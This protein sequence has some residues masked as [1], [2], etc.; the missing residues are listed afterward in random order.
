MKK[1]YATLMIALLGSAA[2]AQNLNTVP[3]G[4]HI[5]R[6]VPQRNNNPSTQATANFYVDYDFSDEDYQVNTNGYQYSRFIWDM[7][8][9][10]DYAAGD[11]SYK[12]AAVDFNTLIDSYNGSA[13]VAFNTFAN[14]T[15]DSV[16]VACGHSNY[17][18]QNDTIIIKVV[19]L[20]S[21]GYPTYPGTILYADTLITN[22][23][24]FA[25]ASWLNSG[26]LYVT[27]GLTLPNSTKFGV[28]VEYYGNPLDTF[29]M[30]C[31]FG[32]LGA[33]QCS[34]LPTLTNYA[35]KSN[36]AP[37][38][39]RHDMRFAL[40]P[41]NIQQLPTSSGADTYYD[42]DGSGN[43][44]AG[45]DAENFNQNWSIWVN[46]TTVTSIDEINGIVGVG[47]NQP[48]PFDNT[49]V[50]PYSLTEN[51]DVALT[52]YDITGKMITSQSA[53]SQGA[54]LHQFTIDGSQL[55][56]G[57]YYYTV[58]AGAGRVTRKMIVQ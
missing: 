14:Y 35:V 47:Q 34:S 43:Y 53:Q 18:G 25:E 45:S 39:Y 48:N 50:I 40:P 15:V 7:N 56:S 29:G 36:W 9:R 8:M 49:T 13:P 11:T 27:P 24:I 58:E 41:N 4:G 55:A 1:I 33:N 37:N 52:I 16:F 38:S 6:N 21:G 44:Q 32:D 3:R 23:S 12:W 17:S 22:T 42:C 57:V 54:G 2:F 28:R 19:Q 46:L 51:S 31:G 30:I 10:Y 26:L 20:S 5:P